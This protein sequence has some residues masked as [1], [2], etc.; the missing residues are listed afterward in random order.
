MREW[1]LQDDDVARWY[2]ESAGLHEYLEYLSLNH[3]YLK[4]ARSKWHAYISMSDYST[5]HRSNVG[6]C[7]EYDIIYLDREDTFRYST[8]CK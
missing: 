8:F 4:F 7:P 3:H 5:T 6:S 1:W 2:F